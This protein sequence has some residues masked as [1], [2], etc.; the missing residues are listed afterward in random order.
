MN[1]LMGLRFG[2]VRY[3]APRR[4]DAFRPT[5]LNQAKLGACPS[6]K[7]ILLAKDERVGFHLPHEQDIPRLED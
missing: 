4:P 2:P 7:Q 1:K 5:S 6:I 3:I